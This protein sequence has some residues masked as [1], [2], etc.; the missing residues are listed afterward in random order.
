MDALTQLLSEPKEKRT[1]EGTL[2]TPVEIAQQPATWSRTCDLIREWRPE[3]QEFL[4]AAGVFSG[5]DERPTVLL[6]GAGTSDYIGKS[7]ASVLRREWDCDV[8]PSPSTDLV[9]HFEDALRTGQKYL[10]ISFSRSGDSPEGVAVLQRAMKTRPDTFHLVVTCNRE[11]Q[12][13]RDADRSDHAM[14]ICLDEAVNDRGLAMT[15]SFSNMAVVGQ[16]LAHIKDPQ[17]YD[18]ILCLLIEAGN[19]LLP[20]AA[21]C[22]ATLAQTEYKKACFVGSGTLAAVAQESALKV[23]EMTAGRT[24]ALSQSALGLRHG[25][26]AVLDGNSLF[27]AFLS[28][29]DRVR[30]YEHDLLTEIGAKKI[31]KA[32]VA[33]GINPK[34]NL[35]GWAENYLCPQASGDIPDEYRA[36]VDVIFGQLLGLFFSLRWGLKPDSPSPTGAITRVVQN[37]TMY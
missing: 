31:A 13:F 6:I 19:S 37:V 27:V 28:G 23:L 35:N 32:R 12:M 33:V 3:I 14:G 8:I 15:S 30:K 10:S 29:D 21:N 16:C 11:G 2:Y 34:A 26:M 18:R 9:T 22:A 24:I 17:R 7:V 20:M 4:S 1:A 5:R 36:P 25:P